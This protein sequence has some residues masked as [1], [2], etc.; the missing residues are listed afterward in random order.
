MKKILKKPAIIT[1]TSIIIIF[2]VFHFSFAFYRMP[3]KTM[4]D[5]IKKGDLLIINKLA[6]GDFFFGI[7]MPSFSKF[8]IDDIIYFLD[9]MDVDAPYYARN[10]I[11]GRVVACPGDTYQ[12]QMRD[13]YINDHLYD[14]PSTIKHSYRIVTKEGIKLDTT[15]FNKYGLSDWI[16]ESS[17]TDLHDKY[18]QMYQMVEDQLIHVY[19]VPMSKEQSKLV[20]NDTLVSFVRLVRSTLPGRYLQ[21][22]PYS[23]YWFWNRWHIKDP[24]DVPQKGAVVNINYR[25]VSAYVDIIEKHE[26]NHVDMTK[27]QKVLINNVITNKYTIKENYYIVLSDNRDRFYD[28]RTW[29][30]VPEKFIIGKVINR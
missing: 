18:K 14:E 2:L 10:R 12:M 1:G 13:I 9:P 17:K 4:E 6:G 30:L 25:T 3:D 5:T 7:K 28:T 19:D 20:E 23:N 8:K 22:W 21:I 24:F 11:V 15:F 29:G 26:G 16:I 27:D